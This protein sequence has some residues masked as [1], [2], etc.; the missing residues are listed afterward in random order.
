MPCRLICSL[1][2]RDVR[3][4]VG[5]DG[6]FLDFGTSF[7]AP[8]VTGTVALLQQYALQHSLPTNAR[9][10]EVMK[11]VL[12][13]SADKL[14]GVQGSTRTAIDRDGLN[15]KQTEAFNNP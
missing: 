8:L 7:S 13:N 4:I 6:S 14:A 10:H 1:P 9:K 15:W 5:N 3:R 11:A 12:M 2:G